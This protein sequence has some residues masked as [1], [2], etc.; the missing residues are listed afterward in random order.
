VR[1]FIEAPWRGESVKPDQLYR[2]L[3]ALY[4]GPYVEIFARRPWPGWDAWGDQLPRVDRSVPEH[5]KE[6]AD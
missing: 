4:D 3:E 1:N 5:M 6:S 2:D